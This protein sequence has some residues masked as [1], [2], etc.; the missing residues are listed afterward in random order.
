MK[1]GRKSTKAK[2][3]EES[4]DAAAP[5]PADEVETPVEVETPADEA[6]VSAGPR[7]AG[8]VDLEGDGVPRV[9]LTSLLIAPADGLELRLQVNEAD[10]SVQSIL[11][12]GEDGAVELRAFAAS[13]GGDMWS[14]VRRQ[15]AAETSRQGGTATESE[16][17]HGTEL[18]CQMTVRTPDGRTGVQPT[19]VV[20]FNGPRWFLRATYLGRPAVQP[21]TAGIFEEAVNSLVVRRGEGPMAPG[22]ALPINLPPQ[23]R[24]MAPA[25]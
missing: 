14:D 2:T 10:G 15:I 8:E 19:R 5:T 24:R 12:T 22:E 23:A 21:E 18:H 9:D 16:G 25:E 6:S 1:F 4:V 3:T 13:R 17:P 7:D 11:L 20:G